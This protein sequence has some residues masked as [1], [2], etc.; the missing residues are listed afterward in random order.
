ML[1]H[2]VKDLRIACFKILS[3]AGDPPQASATSVPYDSCYMACRTHNEDH[4]PE[5]DVRSQ[6]DQ[7]DRFSGEGKGARIGD[8]R[9]D[10]NSPR[11]KTGENGIRKISDDSLEKKRGED[12]EG[13]E[14][15]ECR[16]DRADLFPG[17]V[18]IVAVLHAEPEDNTK[19]CAMEG[20]SLFV[21]YFGQSFLMKRI[22]QQ[23]YQS[24]I[25]HPFGDQVQTVAYLLVRE[26][27]NLLFYSSRFMEEEFDF[28]EGLGGIS[29][30][31]LNHRD[32][33]SPF[34]DVVFDQYGAPLI[35]HQKEEKAV[36]EKCR[37]GK[38]ITEGA[39]FHDLEA[40][41]TPGHAPGSTCFLWKRE[42][43]NILFTGDTFYPRNGVWSVAIQEGKQ[44]EMIRSLEKLKD[45]EV[46]GLIP[47]LFIGEESFGFFK[48]QKE[49]RDTLSL[50]IERL[51]KASLH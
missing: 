40:I 45:L 42:E 12:P 1:F 6:S 16:D 22:T 27:G 26:E 46:S 51:Q 11:S 48:N 20:R 7:G 13:E 47:G 39:V 49:Y 36:S 18:L 32:E 30:Q 23:L 28:I 17:I 4:F 3:Q 14:D 43:G 44:D 19:V 9:S 21:Y 34:C 5:R 8:H 41:H 50:C 35:C 38:T 33:A 25:D 24:R 2:E 29:H 37:V 10:H 15:Q 31:I